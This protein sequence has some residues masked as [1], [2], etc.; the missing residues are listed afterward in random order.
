[1]TA[2]MSISLPVELPV[3][4]YQRFERARRSRGLD[5]S[6][7]AQRALHRWAAFP[8]AEPWDQE[9]VDAYRRQPQDVGSVEAWTAATL[10]TW[11]GAKEPARRRARRTP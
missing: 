10:S 1:M 2:K 8:D 9:Y 5:R 11:Q 6:A 3:E 7:A 4:L